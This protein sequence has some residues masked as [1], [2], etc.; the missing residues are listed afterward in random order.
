MKNSEKKINQR[1]KQKYNYQ[2]FSGS[3]IKNK[4]LQ[5]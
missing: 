5:F 3:K 4:N 2:L 1:F